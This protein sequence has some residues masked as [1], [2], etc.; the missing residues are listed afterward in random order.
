MCNGPYKN[1]D[2]IEMM[3]TEKSRRKLT[4]SIHGMNPRELEWGCLG[5]KEV[6]KL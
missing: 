3:L 5:G 4:N 1:E 6:E 2:D